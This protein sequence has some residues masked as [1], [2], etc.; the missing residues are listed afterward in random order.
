MNTQAALTMVFVGVDPC[1]FDTSRV[2]VIGCG[3]LIWF[4]GATGSH[5]FSWA[6]TQL[7]VYSGHVRFC[8]RVRSL[9]LCRGTTACPMCSLNWFVKSV[10]IFHTNSDIKHHKTNWTKN[11]T[12]FVNR[13]V[14]TCPILQ[15]NSS[16]CSWHRSRSSRISLVSSA[17][18]GSKKFR[19]T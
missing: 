16:T 15:A 10:G 11:S 4:S 18:P 5:K 3:L 7:N 13:I 9:R 14:A 2:F 19:N 6:L 1:A 12:C 8:L 17:W